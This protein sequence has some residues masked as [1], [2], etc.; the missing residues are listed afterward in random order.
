MQLSLDYKN[1]DFNLHYKN[2]T[3]SINDFSGIYFRRPALPNLKGIV[4]EKEMPFIEREIE[5]L[6]SGFF[7]LMSNKNWLNHPK[8][9]FCANS[10]IEQLKVAKDIGFLIPNTLISSNKADILEFIQKENDVIAKAV[11]HGFYEY[12]DK[13]YL[14]FTQK[15]DKDFINKIDY[16]KD[17]PMIFQKQISKKCDIRVNVIG[18]KVFATALL[19]QEWE[20]SKIDWRVWDVCEKFELKHNPISLPLEIEQK[21]IAL[22][23]FFNLNF[24]AIDMVLDTQGNYIFLELNPNGQWAW[25]EEKAGYPIRDTIIDFLSR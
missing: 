17:I 4:L 1:Y 21:C 15:I 16:Y 5:S 8:D 18:E 2:Q 19:S 9:I 22:N 24:S 10:K 13:V 7:R 6:F 14:A 12:D 25:I 11:K 23:R 20:F 3:I